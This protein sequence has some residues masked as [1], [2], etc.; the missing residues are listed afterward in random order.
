MRQPQVRGEEVQQGAGQ[1]VPRI[2]LHRSGLWIAS[3]LQGAA[4]SGKKSCGR[5][6][7]IDI[8]VSP[9]TTECVTGTCPS[10]VGAEKFS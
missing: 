4:S 1:V 8:V 7:R 9:P 3:H 2:Q 5:L 10:L 6:H